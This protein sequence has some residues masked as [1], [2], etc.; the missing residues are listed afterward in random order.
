MYRD[1]RAIDVAMM[2][3]VTMADHTAVDKTI[4]AA[5]EGRLA[6]KTEDVR[7]IVKPTASQVAWARRESRPARPCGRARRGARSAAA[8]SARAPPSA[9]R[10]AREA[11]LPL[12]DSKIGRSVTPVRLGQSKGEGN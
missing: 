6:V 3:A 7:Q 2:A 12:G 1:P 10:P 5:K 11:R 8:R 4:T 9:A